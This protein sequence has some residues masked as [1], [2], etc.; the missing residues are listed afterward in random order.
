MKFFVGTSGYAYKEWKEHFYPKDIAP[1]DMLKYYAGT[2]NAVEINNTFYRMPRESV[3]ANWSEQVPS[4]FSFVLKATRRI[5]HLKRLKDVSAELDYFLQ[6]TSELRKKLGPI[7]V[8]L[9]PNFKK[10]LPRLEEFLKQI[11]KRFR[12][13]MEFRHASWFDDEVYAV[14]ETSGAALVVS[15]SAEEAPAVTSTARWGYL[16]LRREAYEDHD[17]EGWVT[18]IR[19]N[20][21]QE[22]FVFFKH[23]DEGTGPRLGK[24][25]LEMVRA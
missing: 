7:L 11:P 3:V 17:L 19:D 8:Q 5:T 10:D 12:T 24:R 20:G 13:A 16:R 22:V 25:F 15:D 2:F 1:A 9:P 14:L 21:W 23:E 4:G 18:R 6:A